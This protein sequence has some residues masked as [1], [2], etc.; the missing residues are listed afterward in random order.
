MR[1]TLLIAALA[2]AAC[3]DATAPESPLSA[4]APSD[5]VADGRACVLAPLAVQGPPVD[6]LG[7][8]IESQ[9][10][11]A[12]Y[13]VTWR[14]VDDAARAVREVGAYTVSASPPLRVTLTWHAGA[15]QAETITDCRPESP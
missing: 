13:V 8:R 2:L 14:L 7:V 12:G 5:V 11:G 9:L 4:T 10:A 15:Q 3:T 6:A 1:S